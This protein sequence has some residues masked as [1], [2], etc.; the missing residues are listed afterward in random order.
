VSVPPDTL[1]GMT[2]QGWPA[3]ALE[4]YDGLEADN[5]KPYWTAHKAVYEASVLAPMQDLL[6]ELRDEF[7][8]G[9]IFRPYRD[10]RFST[11]KSPYKTAIGATLARGGYVQLSSGGLAAGCGYHGMAP[12]QIERYRRAVADE[13]NGERLPGIIADIEKQ[14]VGIG[15][16]DRLKSVPRGY[17]K[18]H[19]RAD[20]LRNKGL[21]A[22]KEWQP[23]AWLET[24]TTREHLTEFLRAAQ[25]L[26]SWLEANVG[27][28]AEPRR[29]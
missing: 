19:P 15:G 12:D 3:E 10:V 24:R 17:P 8:E 20:L 21:M 28:S 13:V 27:P 29:R 18:D 25:P 1:G 14:D 6:A 26:L 4:F 11:D 2:F 16:G 9:H 5:S 7:G 23:A 22:W